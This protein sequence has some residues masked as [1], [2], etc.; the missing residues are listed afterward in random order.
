MTTIDLDLPPTAIDVTRREPVV[1]PERL[2]T[3]TAFCRRGGA[4]LLEACSAAS[5]MALVTPPDPG[6]LRHDARR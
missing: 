4:V 5:A 6:Q 3:L 1:T 2:A